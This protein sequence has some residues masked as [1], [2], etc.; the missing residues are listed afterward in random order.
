MIKIK[1]PM[2]SKNISSP[3]FSLVNT[4]SQLVIKNNNTQT[5]FKKRY[6]LYHSKTLFD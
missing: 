5:L 2:K 3:V 4:T 1:F 6:Y